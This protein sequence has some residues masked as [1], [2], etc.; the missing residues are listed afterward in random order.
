MS[1]ASNLRLQDHLTATE[2]SVCKIIAKGHSNAEAADQLGVGSRTI[3]S[4]LYS[5]YKKV[6]VKNRTQLTALW[7]KQNG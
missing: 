4:H 6:Q 3:A 5:I 2:L 7:F 1:L